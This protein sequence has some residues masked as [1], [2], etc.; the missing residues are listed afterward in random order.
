MRKFNEMVRRAFASFRAS[1]AALF[2]RSKPAPVATVQ[3]RRK[4]RKDAATSTKPGAKTISGLLDDLDYTFNQLNAADHAGSWTDRRLRDGLRALG[5][6]VPWDDRVKFN[7]AEVTDPCPQAFP[8][9]AFVSVPGL[10]DTAATVYAKFIY[11]HKV[12]KFPAGAR[13]TEVGERYE[14]GVCYH[15]GRNEKKLFWFNFA[16]T[17]NR[18][19]GHIGLVKA[20][21]SVHYRLPG[22]AGTVS[23]NEWVNAGIGLPDDDLTC[24]AALAFNA[25]RARETSWT[26]SAKRAG[27]RVTF[28]IPDN[29]AKGFFSD[30]D[31]TALTADGRM[32]PIMHFVSGHKR[33]LAD[34]RE[35]EVKEHIRGLRE[36]DWNG[37]H[38]AITA[39]KF[40][41]WTADKMRAAASDEEELEGKWAIGADALGAMLAESEDTQHRPK[42][43]LTLVVNN[44]E[45]KAA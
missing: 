29:E 19:T 27:R 28:C 24:Y 39:P 23:R 44:D 36:F 11:A 37:S 12:D 34:G 32:R 16:V 7:V 17:V 43:R 30:R 33:A 22:R 14:C 9:L 13:E 21:Q 38:C 41:A 8:S 10:E 25:W 3:R 1:L 18:N 35:T 4:P 2:G 31:R 26:V 5:P 15:L 45:R 20:R 6:V 42:P 40:H